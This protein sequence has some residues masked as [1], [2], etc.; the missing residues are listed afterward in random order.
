MGLLKELRAPHSLESQIA[1][2]SLFNDGV[3]VTLF[4]A[5]AAMAGL[6]GAEATEP[7]VSAIAEFALR[8]VIGGAALGLGL[9]YA[10]TAR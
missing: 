3:G 10:A 5:I 8:E 9:G 4:L 2:E 7:Q 1:G 6:S